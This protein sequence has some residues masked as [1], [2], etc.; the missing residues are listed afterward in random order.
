MIKILIIFLY[1]SFTYGI[2]V[3]DIHNKLKD[4]IV[5]SNINNKYKDSYYQASLKENGNGRKIIYVFEDNKK[6]KQITYNYYVCEGTKEDYKKLGYESR[7][8]F[9]NFMRNI[10]NKD[11]LLSDEYY[12]LDKKEFKVNDS[13]I[14]KLRVKKT[15]PKCD[16]KGGKGY[17]LDLF[18][19]L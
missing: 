18:L 14:K 5:N 9:E 3:K 7:V 2:T 4:K 17:R 13:E 8:Y 15:K 11:I 19:I 16:S 10:F 6:I 12:N 1:S